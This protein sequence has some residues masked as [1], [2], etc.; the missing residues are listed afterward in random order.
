[1]LVDN[2]GSPFVVAADNSG[3]LH[4][5]DLGTGSPV[6]GW[7]GRTVGFGVRA[8]LSS[9]GS[10]VYVPVATGAPQEFPQYR[11]FAGNGNPVWNSNPGLVLPSNPSYGFLLS[12][13]AIAQVGGQRRGFTGS[14]G[15]LL[16]GLDAATGGRTWEFM[17]ADST[18]ATPAVAD[19]FGTGRPQVVVSTNAS[20]EFA[21]DLNGG[22]L[23]VMTDDGRQICSAD[24]FVAGETHAASGYNNSSP[25][26]GVVDGRPLIVFGSTGP[27]QYGPGGNQVVGYNADCT[28]RW[29]SPP[30]AG[31]ALPSPTLADVRGRGV[32]DVVQLVAQA[33]G[34]NTYPRVYT[35]DSSTGAVVAD[36]GAGLRGFGAALAYPETLQVTT[37]DVNGDGA[38]D[39]FVPARQGALVVLDGRTLGVITTVPTDLVI[40]NT[41]IV[42]SAP[43][44]VRL[45]L[46]GYNGLGAQVSSYL[47]SGGSLGQRGWHMFGG[48]PRLGGVQGA[49]AGPFD[50]LLEGGSLQVGG[51]LRSNGHRLVVQADGNMVLY[52]AGGG[53][54]WWT[55]TA[56]PGGAALRVNIDGSLE[57]VAN[58]SG[59]RLWT[60]PAGGNGFERLTLGTDGVLRIT[61]A[62]PVPS[63][64]QLSTERLVWDNLGGAMPRDRIRRGQSL[65]SGQTLVSRGGSSWAALQPDGNLTVWRN[66]QLLWQSGTR[67]YTA[68]SKLWLQGGD[69]NLVH[70]NYQPWPIANY[71]VAGGQELVVGDDGILR[72]W[73]AN[74]SVLWSTAPAP[75]A[76]RVK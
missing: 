43:G 19:L 70:W 25:S 75:V 69:G 61:S 53:A 67:D 51:E 49:P 64:R 47:I 56:N 57:L 24:M 59:A 76:T 31:Q 30:L 74:G 5:L 46:A 1:V 66:G 39:L 62:W 29:T 44:G 58:G 22:L 50:T 13:L 52:R 18:M 27:V 65:P 38:Q 23:R 4:A 72:V 40:Q 9:D 7:A 71:R 42:T 32:P 36:T 15:Q 34:P 68:R 12:G 14:S 45:T 10:D 55:G 54:V 26:V 60:Q 8:P 6:A 33:D 28:L 35:I 21:Q 16:Y 2:G 63:S 20:R 17:N 41:P 48:S 37:A 73:A 3:A 11:K